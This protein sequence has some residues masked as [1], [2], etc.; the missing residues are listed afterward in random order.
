MK[1]PSIQTAIALSLLCLGTSTFAQSSRGLPTGSGSSL[2]IYGTAATEL[3]HV[4]NFN[5][6]SRIG[7]STR[8]ENSKV[9]ASRLGFIGSED[10]GGGLSSVFNLEMGYALD[11]GTQSSASYFFNRGSY[12]GLRGGFGTM[13]VGRQWDV[14][15][16]VLGRYFIF[17]GYGVFQFSEFAA[18]SDTVANSVK[19]VTPAM[20]GVTA[21]ALYGFGEGA[22]SGHTTEFALNYAAG[23]PFEAGATYRRQKAATGYSTQLVT[24]GASYMLPVTSAGKFRLHGGY[25]YSK[26]E[27]PVA[28][29]TS[30]YDVGVVW[31]LPS[32]N[33]NLTL[34]YVARDQRGT[35]NDS[36]FVRLGGEYFLSKRT[37]FIANVVSLTN[38]GNASQKFFGQGAQGKGQRVLSVGLRHAF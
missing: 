23:G 4:S 32:A 13:T 29:K 3:V 28:R 1:T 19:Y 38:K 24:L 14:E 7:N 30:A 8:L 18:I 37:S 36:R 9:T 16:D 22:T 10:L 35:D 11:T 15:D 17:G 27:D 26:P 25:A 12:V 2:N 6:G 20:G 5:D 21:R 31:G 33:A 34:D